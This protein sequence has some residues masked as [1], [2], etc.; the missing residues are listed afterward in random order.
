MSP[1]ARGRIAAILAGRPLV[2]GN[3]VV[4]EVKRDA[5]TPK[6][7]HVLFALK[8]AKAATAVIHTLARDNSLAALTVTLSHGDLAPCTPVGMVNRDGTI[9]AWAI[10]GGTAQKFA[11]GFAGPDLTLGSQALRK[12]SAACDSPIWFVA[13]DDSITWGLTFDLAQAARGSGDGGLALHAS[14]VAVLTSAPVP[15]RKVADE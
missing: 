13:A 3:E 12:L 9:A 6:V 11:R 4:V 15:G 2:A 5:K 1:D 8:K 14:Q 10:G 7:G